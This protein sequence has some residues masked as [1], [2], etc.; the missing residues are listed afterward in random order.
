MKK[1]IFKMS[2]MAALMAASASAMAAATVT[3]NSAVGQ[4]ISAT[5][6]TAANFGTTLLGTTSMTVRLAKTGNTVT[7]VSGDGTVGTGTS[8][9]MTITGSS[10]SNVAITWPSNASL[11]G[12]VTFDGTGAIAN[13]AN[14]LLGTSCTSLN[15]GGQITIPQGTPVASYNGEVTLIL[16][17][18]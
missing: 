8:G 1:Q 17:Y 3:V 14:C 11:G 9:V 4:A 12:G 16:N 7:S 13:P 10:G 5:T 18:L 6:V 2:A 15:F